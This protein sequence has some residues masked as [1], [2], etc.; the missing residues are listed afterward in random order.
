VQH[1]Q[2]FAD[3]TGHVAEFEVAVSLAGAGESADHSAESAAIDERDF[4][5]V[6]DDGAAVVQEPGNVRTQRFTL[7]TGDDA[8]VAAHDRDASDLARIE[9]K[10]KWG[11]DAGGGPAK[12]PHYMRRGGQTDTAIGGTVSTTDWERCMRTASRA[13]LDRTAG[14]GCPHMFLQ[15]FAAQEH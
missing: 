5:Q 6:Q 7:T 13:W 2:N 14:S 3:V 11:S 10:T 15:S 9:G 8:P 12:S 1:F 4:A